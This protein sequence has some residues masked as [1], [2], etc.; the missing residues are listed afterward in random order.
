MA[1]FHVS[2]R[3]LFVVLMTAVFGLTCWD[4][5]RSKNDISG[6]KTW[7]FALQVNPGDS[8]G[9]VDGKYKTKENSQTGF[10]EIADSGNHAMQTLVISPIPGLL[11]AWG[12][13]EYHECPFPS[14]QKEDFHL[15][16]TDANQT[17]DAVHFIHHHKATV[18][19]LIAATF[20][21]PHAL[22]QNLILNG[23]GRLKLL[24]LKSSTLQELQVL[25]DPALAAGKPKHF[26][27]ATTTIRKF[28]RFYQGEAV[29]TNSTKPSAWTDEEIVCRLN[30][31]LEYYRSIGIQHFYIIDNEQDL[32]KPNLQVLSKNDVTYIR[33]PHSVYDFWNCERQQYTVTGQG[34]LENSI[35][36]MAHTE[37]LLVLDVDEF[38]VLGN[39]FKNSLLN[40]VDYFQYMYCN[41][42]YDTFV[43]LTC[44]PLHTTIYEQT[45]AIM[46]TS[47][48][49]NNL[50]KNETWDEFS[51]RRKGLLKP[52]LVEKLAVHYPFSIDN[53]RYAETKVP[54]RQAWMGHF[55]NKLA[56]RNATDAVW[57]ALVSGLPLLTPSMRNQ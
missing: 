35:I 1:H 32:A 34:I 46:F 47:I 39:R 8:Y 25:V 55:N 27:S 5:L 40:L 43:N 15:L 44:H 38:I 13:T 37:W 17:F 4:L 54:P 26:L 9:L 7:R 29:S 11:F 56:H 20:Q 57:K 42:F 45:Y 31:W 22:W 24:N 12:T 19:P 10:I 36:R 28:Y 6:N 3:M 16:S 41:G 48:Y 18:G 50:N 21:V 52:S 49:L 53:S 14:Y 2:Q 23:G 30:V 33:S 51:F